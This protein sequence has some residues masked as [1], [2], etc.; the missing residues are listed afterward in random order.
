[1]LGDPVDTFLHHEFGFLTRN[2]H[3]RT[4]LQIEVAEGRVAG[5]MLQRFTLGP[6][7]HHGVESLQRSVFTALLRALLRQLGCFASHQH[8]LVD[9]LQV[10]AEYFGGQ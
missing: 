9:G 4:N 7:I 6:A 8:G 3:A 1:M 10:D 2:E 5:D